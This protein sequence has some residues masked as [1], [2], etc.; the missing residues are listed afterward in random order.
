MR[1]AKI[2]APSAAAGLRLE[3]A[4]MSQRSSAKSSVDVKRPAPADAVR[5]VAID[6]DGTLLNDSK[7]VSDQ[8]VEAL[9][10]LPERGV[11]VIIAS[12]RPPRSV[13]A[14]YQ[15]LKLDTWQINY[16]GALIWD[17][18]NQQPVFHRPLRASLVRE[19][20]ELSRDMFDETI[21]SCEVLDKWLTDR[22]D[23]SHTTETGRLFKPDL[24]A[25]LEQI[26]CNPVTKL[27]LLGEPRII[28]RLE[29]LLVE[30]FIDRVTIVKTDDDLLQIMDPRVSKAVA[31]KKAATHYGI[32][33][34]EVMA[35]G[36]APNDVG[37]L[38]L[39][40]VAV[41]MDNAHGV[42][43]EVA[44]WVAPSNNDHGVHAALVKYGLCE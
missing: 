25:P 16:N 12:A 26:C 3:S 34:S 11:K 30:S 31:L 4:S 17:E 7:Q 21:V 37:M 33:M 28:L 14:V 5:L 9:C 1:K 36:D 43:K 22:E 32:P 42:V 35:I 19:I 27:M 39:A 29:A 2:S 13:R 24:I 8:T 41:A 38:Q 40:G 20:V 44:D 15:T 10:G 6:L 23:Q 18:P